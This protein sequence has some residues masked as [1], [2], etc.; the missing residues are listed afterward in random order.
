MEFNLPKLD[1]HIERKL[2]LARIF[3]EGATKL[4]A[5]ISHDNPVLSANEVVDYAWSLIPDA[6][7]HMMPADSED[8]TENAINIHEGYEAFRRVQE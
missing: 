5:Q 2:E 4:V 3:G 1:K 8:L 7:A 6:T